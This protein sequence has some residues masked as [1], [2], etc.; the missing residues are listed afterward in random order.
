MIDFLRATLHFRGTGFFLN[1]TS[2]VGSGTFNAVETRTGARPP[3]TTIKTRIRTL[4]AHRSQLAVV[5]YDIEPWE[6]VYLHVS[7]LFRVEEG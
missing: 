3:S 4:D 7:L 6:S 5:L 2:C 1:V